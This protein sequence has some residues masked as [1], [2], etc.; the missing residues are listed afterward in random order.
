MKGKEKVRESERDARRFETEQSNAALVAK[1]LKSKNNYDPLWNSGPRPP[2]IWRVGAGVVGMLFL[3]FGAGFFSVGLGD[4][5][6]ALFAV[7][8]LFGLASVRPLWNAFKPRKID[9]LTRNGSIRG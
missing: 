3:F 4:H 2:L 1:L 8:A 6:V 7:A 9:P 5:S